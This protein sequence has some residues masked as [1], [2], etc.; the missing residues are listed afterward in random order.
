MPNKINGNNIYRK[1]AYYK[2]FKVLLGK[3]IKNK[4]N[5]LK[6]QCFLYYSKKIIFQ[7]LVINIQEIQKKRIISDF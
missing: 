1:D 2:H 6:N 5:E 4:I 7:L 3:Y